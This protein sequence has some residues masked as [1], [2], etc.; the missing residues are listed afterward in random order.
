MS[1]VGG[2]FG[3]AM[4]IGGSVEYQGNNDPHFHGNVHLV[5]VYQYKTIAEIADM[6]QANL[7]T[8]DDIN[9]YQSWVCRE[10]HFDLDEHNAAL[11]ELERRWNANNSDPACDKLCRIPAYIHEDS[12]RS[13]WLAE[14][15][16]CRRRGRHNAA[17]EEL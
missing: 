3:L 9:T 5:S 17:L 15:Q 13:L 1:L 2:S 6:M 11:E 10:D 7:L 16:C 4:A 8:L 14:S 12:T